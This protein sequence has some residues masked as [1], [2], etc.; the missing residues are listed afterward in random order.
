MFS[1]MKRE[2]GYNEA[3]GVY[4]PEAPKAP[5]ARALFVDGLSNWSGLGGRSDLRGGDGRLVGVAPEARGKVDQM[6]IEPT[7]E[8]ALAVMNR[9]SARVS[10]NKRD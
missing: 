10:F 4:L 3:M 6:I 8:Q 7:L 5:Q 2:F 1:E 9:N